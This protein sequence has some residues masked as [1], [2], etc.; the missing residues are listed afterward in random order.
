[1]RHIIIDLEF[2]PVSDKTIR[3]RLKQE[4]IE[5]GATMLNENYELIDCFDVLVKPEYTSINSEVYNLTGI[6]KSNITNAPCFNEALDL[7]MEWVGTDSFRLYQW[8]S[9]DKLQIVKECFYKGISD[10]HSA[11]CNKYWCDIQRLYTRVFHRYG[12]PTLENALKELALEYDGQKHRACDDAKNTASLLQI[13][14]VKDRYNKV[15]KPIRD[16]MDAPRKSTTLGELVG[17][18][19]RTLLSLCEVS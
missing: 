16:I 18:D 19:L 17:I 5:I 2:T 12:V 6:T 4:T 11:F 14:A 7:L 13:M 10:K 15:A 1:M 3:R 8:S 9:N